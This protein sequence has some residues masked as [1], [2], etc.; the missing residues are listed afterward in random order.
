MDEQLVTFFGRC[1]FKPNIPSKAGKAEIKDLDITNGY[2]PKKHQTV[3]LVSTLHN[4]KIS[5]NRKEPKVIDFTAKPSQELIQQIKLSGRIP[6]SR[7]RIGIT[8]SYAPS[9]SPAVQP[10]S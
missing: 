1:P 4:S 3:Y 8:Q 7:E 5:A 6:T 2:V 10:K 9:S